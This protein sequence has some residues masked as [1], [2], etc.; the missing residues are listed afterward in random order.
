MRMRRTASPSAVMFDELHAQKSREQWD[1]L[2]SGSGRE[3]SL[4]FPR[5]PRR[6]SSR[7]GICTE[8]RSYLVSV[9]E[10]RRQG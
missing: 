5:S 1:V 6:V 9:L 8:I 10:G 7:N 4:C 3:S 2:E